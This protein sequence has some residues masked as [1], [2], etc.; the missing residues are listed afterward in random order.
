MSLELITNDWRFRNKNKMSNCHRRGGAGS[1]GPHHICAGAESVI[2]LHRLEILQSQGVTS[3]TRLRGDPGMRSC[4]RKIFCCESFFS[5]KTLHHHSQ[6][7][8]QTN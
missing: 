5:N 1:L 3:V 6:I 7:Y 8:I 4:G 2:I